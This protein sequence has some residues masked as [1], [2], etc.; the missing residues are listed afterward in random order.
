MSTTTSDFRQVCVPDCWTETTCPLDG[1]PLSPRGRAGPPGTPVCEHQY[2]ATNARHL[3]DEHDDE[4]W[5][6][7]PE[8]RVAH[9]AECDRC[10][11][12][13]DR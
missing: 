2:D 5:R 8:G 12:E 9:L 11:E 3:W 4:R 7:D 13:N 6:F 10:R 1:M